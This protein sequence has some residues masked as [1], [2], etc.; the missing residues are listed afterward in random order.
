[1][2]IAIYE[3]EIKTGKRGAFE[4]AWLK[5]TQGIYKDCGS[6][7]SRLHSTGDD[8]PNTMVGYAQWPDRASWEAISLVES[9]PEYREASAEMHACL[10]KSRTVYKMQV[11]SDYLQR[12]P[13]AI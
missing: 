4:A 1:M 6:L 7:G 11:E 9:A 12:I 8:T 2:F 3:F 5:V 10:A 13:F